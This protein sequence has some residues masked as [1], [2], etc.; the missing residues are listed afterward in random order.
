MLRKFWRGQALVTLWEAQPHT[1]AKIQILR[2]FLH[3]WFGV[4]GQTARGQTLVYID[5]FAG[6][7][8]YSNSATGSPVA[9][10]QA[11]SE[12]KSGLGGRWVAGGVRLYF[13]EK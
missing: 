12:I 4:H 2:S 9:A 7:G 11:V 5:G 8:R 6:P 13:I 10:M 3:A 1:L